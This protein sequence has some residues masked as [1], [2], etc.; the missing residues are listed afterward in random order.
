[1]VNEFMLEIAEEEKYK[2][3]EDNVDNG[4]GTGLAGVPVRLVSPQ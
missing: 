3:A 1:M 4:L 2:N